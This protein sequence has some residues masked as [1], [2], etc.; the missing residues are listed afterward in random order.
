MKSTFSCRKPNSSTISLIQSGYAGAALGTNDN[1]R[2]KQ[3][4]GFALPSS[5]TCIM[6]FS[7]P[8]NEFHEELLL[9]QD[10]N[11]YGS[12]F[13]SSPSE[14][15]TFAP[16]EKLTDAFCGS[17]SAAALPSSFLSSRTFDRT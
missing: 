3:V 16:N 1:N 14:F 2:S 15:G 10:D 8:A 17:I 6:I 9:S 5:A 12:F 13:S 7:G 11:G 4:V